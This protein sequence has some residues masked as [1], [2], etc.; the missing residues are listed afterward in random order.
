M[1]LEQIEKEIF[2]SEDQFKY[3]EFKLEYF[4]SNPNP[5]ILI[6]ET[7]KN[8]LSEIHEKNKLIKDNI[9]K[10]LSFEESEK[11]FHN[12]R[13]LDSDINHLV[14]I[15]GN[16]TFKIKAIKGITL[17]ISEKARN[18]NDLKSSFVKCVSEVKTFETKKNST[19]SKSNLSLTNLNFIDQN[20]SDSI[21]T[22]F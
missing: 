12:A 20:I 8:F 1:D 10:S 21:R 6:N 22:C 15:R 9:F 5:N 13:I 4:L 2:E 17:F 3:Q 11:L 14:N 7:L 19:Q 16:L 18:L